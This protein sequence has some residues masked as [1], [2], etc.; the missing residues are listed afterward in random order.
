LCLCGFLTTMRRR[1]KRDRLIDSS[2]KLG[3]RLRR[4]IIAELRILVWEFRY[5]FGALFIVFILGTTLVHYYHKTPHGR[6]G[7]SEAFYHT[8]H[9]IAASPTIGDFPAESKLSILFI[10]LPIFGLLFLADTIARLGSLLFQ[11]RS[12]HKEW[13]ILLASTYSNHVIVCGLGHVGYRIVQNLLRNQI[14]CVAIETSENGFVQEIRDLGV[15]VII[16]DATREEILQKANI[17]QAR[18]IIIATNNDL[19][20]LEIALDARN[21]R[22]DIRI[23]MRMFD[24]KMARKIGKGFNIQYVFSTSAIAAPVFAAAV[25]ERNVI[26]SFVFND[27]QLNTVEITIM[28]GSKLIGWTLDKLRHEL[29]LTVALYQDSTII[30][31]NPSP[32]FTLRPGVKLLVITTSESLQE[33]SLLNTSQKQGVV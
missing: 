1:R 5:S 16:A 29:E 24:E 18:A 30:D 14:D 6:P 32:E 3:V 8:L 27:V 13:Q 11:K 21:I 28:E 19:A 4:R 23:V 33:L 26:N 2:V 10:L 17:G 22:P 25:T 7:W 20:N 31:W 12:Q 9:S 15:P